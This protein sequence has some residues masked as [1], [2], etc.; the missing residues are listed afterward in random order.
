MSFFAYSSLAVFLIEGKTH[1]LLFIEN[2]FYNLEGYEFLH[3]E[4]V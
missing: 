4:E 2:I 3:V 1:N